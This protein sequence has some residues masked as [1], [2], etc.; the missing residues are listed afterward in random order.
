MAATRLHWENAFSLIDPQIN[1]EGVH[2][3]P[4]D[5][6]CPVDA[7]FYV[8]DKQ[9]HIRLN[10]HDYFEVFYLEKGELVCRIQDRLFTMREGDLVVISSTQYHTMQ[11]P[12]R[13][14]MPARA[15]AAALYFMPEAIRSTDG[16]GEDTEYLMP[17]LLQDVT[18][19]H[20][21]AARTGVPREVFNLIKNIHAELPAT[22][23]RARLAVRTY[24]KMA[25]LL[26]VNY[27]AD[28]R[29]TVETFRRKQ[30][31]IEKL[32]PIFDYIESHYREPI[33]IETAAGM[34]G[35]SKPHFMR[36]FKQV[37][38]QPFINYLNHFRIA[39]AQALL[40]TTELSVAE[41]SQDVG[42]CDQSYFG[43]IFR[44]LAQMTPL[45]YKRQYGAR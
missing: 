28:H 35:M 26:L 16:S 1:A 43:L 21:I 41:V 17:F 19:P 9:H 33:L 32:R 29:G 6:A 10:R 14:S 38:G 25:L 23:V 27:F 24:L 4:F 18:F 22:N 31:A 44:K 7:R 3:W 40:V 13:V 8:Y 34:M 30:S 37:T 45:Q 2:I 39:K 12:Q 42:F 36:L 5:H 15:R 20:V 11:L